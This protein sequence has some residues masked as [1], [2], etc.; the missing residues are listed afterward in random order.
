M[1][2]TYIEFEYAPDRIPKVDFTEYL[3]SVNDSDQYDD[4]DSDESESN[5]GLIRDS[6]FERNKFRRLAKKLR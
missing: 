1:S 4:D 2:H 3:R 5:I 6:F